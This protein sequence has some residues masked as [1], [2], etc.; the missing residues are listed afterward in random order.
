MAVKAR[1]SIKNPRLPRAEALQRRLLMSV[2]IL[3]GP[4]ISLGAGTSVFQE[5]HAAE[6][7]DANLAVTDPRCVLLT[8]ASVQLTGYVAGEDSL[9]FVNQPRISG[10]WNSTSGILTLV[11]FATVAQYQAAL[12]SVTY[13]NTSFDRDPA[14]R[15]AIFIVTDPASSSAPVARSIQLVTLDLAPSITVPGGQNILEDTDLV[16][17]S[18]AG[19]AITV[20]DNYASVG[21]EQLTLTPSNGSLSI[22]N[23]ASLVAMS[24]SPAGVITLDGTIPALNAA[25]DGM[26]FTPALHAY[27]P[28]AIRVQINDL[29]NSGAGSIPIDITPVAHTPILTSAPMVVGNQSADRL[30]I[31]PNPLDDSLPGYFQISGISGGSLLAGTTMGPVANGQFIPFA[32]G[33][34]GLIFVA[35]GDTARDGQLQ[36]AASTTD[37]SSGLGGTVIHATLSFPQIRIVTAANPGFA[38]QIEASFLPT[39]VPQPP[40]ARFAIS[41]Q[42]AAG[43]TIAP[44]SPAISHALDSQ[45]RIA[46]QIASIADAK[47]RA[48]VADSR[49]SLALLPSVVTSIA[50]GEA[51][52]F[53]Q[54]G[55]MSGA[56]H[57]AASVAVPWRNIA[58]DSAASFAVSGMQMLRELDAIRRR[59]TSDASLRIWA[60]TAAILTAGG[61]LG[62]IL[63][64]TRGGSLVSSV[65]SS[66]PAWNV[67]DPLPI[68]DHMA[69]SG[70]AIQRSDEDGLERLVTR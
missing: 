32:Q 14:S 62:Y 22:A 52:I 55:L 47:A 66:M 54:G 38:P 60:G 46:P 70:S 25:L 30:T 29:G 5:H 15:S 24:V 11:G 13:Q 9:G 50:R 56:K 4:A 53:A 36:V 2:A 61:S 34:S 67:V 57:P 69:Q 65:V 18:S 7:I 19:N 23:S 27:G 37:S 20:A 16:F 44:A 21:V 28:A 8:G 51:G 49:L 3:P 40:G 59:I 31:A 35:T 63:W 33:E 1:I 17:S 12:R 58:I 6:P 42:G 48:S 45:E 26:T 68:L 43:T 39:P 41:A 64:L 10:S